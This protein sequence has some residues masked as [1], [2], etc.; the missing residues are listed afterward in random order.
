MGKNKSASYRQ[1]WNMID[2]QIKE[3]KEKKSNNTEQNTS[4]QTNTQSSKT[5]CYWCSRE[6]SGNQTIIHHIVR[7][8]DFKFH[9][10]CSEEYVK[11]MQK[12]E[13]KKICVNDRC[14]YNN[15]V[16]GCVNTQYNSPSSSECEERMKPINTTCLSYQCPDCLIAENICKKGPDYADKC[17]RKTLGESKTD[18]TKTEPK[19]K[20]TSHNLDD[21]IK[22]KI[23]Y[24]LLGH[25]FAHEK[26]S[27]IFDTLEDFCISNCTL[28]I[29]CKDCTVKRYMGKIDEVGV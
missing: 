7:G 29:E 6:I 5:L 23:D 12:L 17:I 24:L 9:M 18:L 25:M 8:T 27:D 26:L 4:T 21:T 2:R 16:G 10:I 11:M 1:F 14:A 3:D 28:T 19:I 15:N 13:S 22:N 20:I